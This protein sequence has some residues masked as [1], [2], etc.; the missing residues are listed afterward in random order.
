MTIYC[1][2]LAHH[3]LYIRD[4]DA[5]LD[6]YQQVFGMKLQN[7]MSVDNREY[8]FLGFDHA[9]RESYPMLSKVPQ[10]VLQ[11][12][13]DPERR[14]DNKT[15]DKGPIGYWK[16]AL[17]V[18]DLNVAYSRLVDREITVSEP[19]QVPD[20]AYLCHCEDPDGYCIELIQHRFEHNHVNQT[21]DD[22]FPLGTPVSFS[23][24]TCRVRDPQ[25]SIAFYEDIL[26]LH[27]VS[28][29]V[30]AHRGFTLY[31]LS[32]DSEIPPSDDIEDIRIRE[33][34][35]QR[36]YAL[37]ELQHVWGTELEQDFC[38]DTSQAT[39][40]RSI[41]MLSKSLATSIHGR[42]DHKVFDC[43]SMVLKDPDGYAVEVL[44]ID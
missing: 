10:C 8:L 17:A 14:F 7:R 25:P 32:C 16:I 37:L 11:L 13:F 41:G 40:F 27:L 22:R 19:F 3:S 26:G 31:F 2:Q 34:L 33:W 43:P 35:W 39:G 28:K 36:P 21:P 9:M 29:Q 12:V 1:N 23:L 42:T 6:F 5:S 30:V 20:V 24:I 18:E 15:S 44:K 38:Y 4:P